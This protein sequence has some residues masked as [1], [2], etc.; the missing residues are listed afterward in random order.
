MDAGEMSIAV[1]WQLG[2]VAITNT[3]VTTWAIMALLAL[4]CWLLSRRLQ[5]QPGPLQTAVEGVIVAIDQAIREVAPDHSRLLLPFVGSLWI[6]LV[7]ANLCSLIPGVH[8]PTRDLSTTSGLAL[9]VFF[10]A[11]WSG[12]RAQGVGAYLK[13]YLAPSPVMLPFH[14]ISELSRTIA[15]AVRLFGNM[16]SLEMAALLI[17]M[18]AG[19]LAPVPILMLH[20]IEALV[21]AY[22]FGMLALIYVAGGMQS[23]SSSSGKE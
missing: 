9:L 7:V 16:M 5:L 11:H 10:Y 2:P 17:L 19:F 15:L 23:I 13:H 4:A 18:V 3:V 14:I 6:F 22:I 1:I 21:Q 20:V 8:S 12:I